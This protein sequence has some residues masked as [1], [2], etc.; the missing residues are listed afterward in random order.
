MPLFSY[1]V[2]RIT[3]LK[4]MQFEKKYSESSNGLDAIEIL[5]VC[6]HAW[7]SSLALENVHAAW[8]EHVH[9]HRR[10]WL[11]VA[12]RAAQKM[13]ISAAAATF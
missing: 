8:S 1:N 11:L 10:R 12:A 3:A 2:L 4:S 13:H 5:V 7:I 6:T 9:R